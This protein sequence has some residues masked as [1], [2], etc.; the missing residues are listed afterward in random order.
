M[1]KLPNPSKE[2]LCVSEKSKSKNLSRMRKVAMGEKASTI[3]L[4][5]LRC[6]STNGLEE[7]RLTGEENAITVYTVATG[8]FIHNKNSSC[9]FVH[10]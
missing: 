1:R 5:F 9:Y 8:T 4:C 2:P 7:F 10:F 3:L 6:A